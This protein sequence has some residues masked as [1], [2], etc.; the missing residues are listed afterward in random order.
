MDKQDACRSFPRGCRNSIDRRDFMGAVG[1]SALAL[2]PALAKLAS[3][4]ARW[5][6]AEEPNRP[7]GEAKGIFPGRVVWISA[8]RLNDADTGTSYYLARVKLTASASE[9]P[10][11]VSLYPGMPAEVMI[12]TG[13]R[14]FINY[15]F[16]PLSRSFRRAFREK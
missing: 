14:T 8:D 12:L 6:P 5:A 16:A 1:L 3:E 7:V 4:S 15:L 9:L 13:E 11:D 10:K 2:N